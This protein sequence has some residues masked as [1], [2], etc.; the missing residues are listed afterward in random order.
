MDLI[1]PRGYSASI[2]MNDNLW[3]TGGFPS[4]VSTEFVNVNYKRS[5][6]GPELALNSEGILVFVPNIVACPLWEQPLVTRNVP[7]L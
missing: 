1:Y 2:V 5:I 3:V 6:P 4:S 7:F